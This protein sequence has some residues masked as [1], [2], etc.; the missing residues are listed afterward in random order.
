MKLGL[1]H[2]LKSCTSTAS[3][4]G[5]VFLVLFWSLMGSRAH[6]TNQKILFFTF[7]P[8]ILLQKPFTKGALTLYCSRPSEGNIK[9]GTVRRGMVP[10]PLLLG[11][12]KAVELGNWE[13]EETMIGDPLRADTLFKKHKG[14]GVCTEQ[15][16]GQGTRPKIR[17]LVPALSVCTACVCTRVFCCEWVEH[18]P[19]HVHSKNNQ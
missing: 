2:K 19:E 15:W 5:V 11:A 10:S 14:I 16:N 12:K 8:R 6:E 1:V 13:T 9:G 18:N 4:F 17:E 3:I 7:V